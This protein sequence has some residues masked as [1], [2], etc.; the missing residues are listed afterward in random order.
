MLR[1]LWGGDFP[2]CRPCPWHSLQVRHEA[3]QPVQLQVG[4]AVE[5]GQEGHGVVLLRHWAHRGQGEGHAARRVPQSLAR[6]GT[7]GP[8]SRPAPGDALSHLARR[9][10]LRGPWGRRTGPP[11]RAAPGRWQRRGTARARTGSSRRRTWA[12]RQDRQLGTTPRPPARTRVPSVPTVP[13]PGSGGFPR[14]GKSHRFP[15]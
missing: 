8:G 7:S 14:A 9:T 1:A 5:L 11:C 4:E 15:E 3:L 6:L 2:L 13:P 12:L 10:P